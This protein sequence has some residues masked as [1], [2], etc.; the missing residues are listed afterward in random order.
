MIAYSISG[1]LA[2][3]AGVLLMARL[4]SGQPTVGVN[5]VMPSVRFPCS[6]RCF[7][8][9]WRGFCLWYIDRGIID[10]SNLQ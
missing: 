1:A 8:K 9:W 6:W 10:G 3:L 4:A 7:I 5:W 2:A